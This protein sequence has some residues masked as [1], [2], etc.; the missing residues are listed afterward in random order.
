MLMPVCDWKFNTKGMS[1][2]L[3]RKS[4][5]YKRKYYNKEVLFTVIRK[6]A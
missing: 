1:D 2:N 4:M 5:M 3:R 6:S